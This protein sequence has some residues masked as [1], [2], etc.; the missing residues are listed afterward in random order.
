MNQTGSAHVLTRT[1]TY[2]DTPVD[3]HKHAR[4]PHKHARIPTQTRSSHTDG[5][6]RTPALV[7]DFVRTAYIGA[8]ADSESL[9]RK[10]HGKLLRRQWL[11]FGLENSQ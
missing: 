5:C 6:T 10:S 7:V 8:A 1:Q 11:I 2:T 3:A 4:D 9:A